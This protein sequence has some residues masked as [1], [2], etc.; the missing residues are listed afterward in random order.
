MR[1]TGPLL[2]VLG[3]VCIVWGVLS[4]TLTIKTAGYLSRTIGYQSGQIAERLTREEV[5]RAFDRSLE[6]VPEDAWERRDWVARTFG[7][8][9]VHAMRDQASATTGYLLLLG[10]LCCAWGTVETWSTRRRRRMQR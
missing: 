5:A 8:E 3:L 10:L 9:M 6:D 7:R 1:A 2:I 4:D